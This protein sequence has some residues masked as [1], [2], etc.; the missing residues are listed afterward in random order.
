MKLILRLDCSVMLVGHGMPRSNDILM[1]VCLQEDT[2]QCCD[3]KKLDC[4]FTHQPAV[5]WVD[6]R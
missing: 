4:A 5:E 3:A 2:K 6:C 1:Q